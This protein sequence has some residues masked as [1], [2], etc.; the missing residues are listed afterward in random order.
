MISLDMEGKLKT[1]WA[2]VLDSRESDLTSDTNFFETGGDSVA[3]IRL[4]ALAHESGISTDAQTVFAHPVLSDLADVCST[5]KSIPKTAVEKTSSAA[6]ETAPPAIGGGLLDSFKI[7]N[8][9][10][11]Q[12]D[13]DAGAIQD[14][15]P[16]SPFQREIMTSSHN[17]GS[18][19]FQAV[20]ELEAGSEGRARRT[21]EVLKEKTP[22]FRTRIVQHG[23]DLY[24][25]VLK[26]GIMW[27][28]ECT[29][30]ESYK[31]RESNKR[32]SYGNPLCRYAVVRN[33]DKTYF[34]W[35]MV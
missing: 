10:I 12:C 31:A 7:V 18:Y 23:T 26:E 20:F 2:Q 35:T 25:V 21:F 27:Q 1:L 14:I 4:V 16:C 19:L 11:L 22:V 29:S 34:V 13:V 17:Y 30:L 15:M 28:E 8:N 32:M 5:T 6:G 33:A 3:V 9:C 24:Q